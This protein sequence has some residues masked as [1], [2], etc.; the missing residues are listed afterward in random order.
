MKTFKQYLN[1][2]RLFER[3]F[4]INTNFVE[5]IFKKLKNEL[6]EQDFG[7][8]RNRRNFK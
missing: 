5:D 6:V 1:E 7:N 8:L 3:K 2:N 4:D